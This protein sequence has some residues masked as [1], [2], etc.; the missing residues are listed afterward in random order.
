MLERALFCTADF[1]VVSDRAAGACEPGSG[2]CAL[3]SDA[4]ELDSGA[5]EAG[6]A[7]P[8]SGDGDRGGQA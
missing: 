5:A 8:E 3:D 4:L 7:T 1:F 6:S 2:A